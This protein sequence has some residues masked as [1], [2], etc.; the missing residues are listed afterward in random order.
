MAN[1][2]L[3]KKEENLYTG[4]IKKYD[5]NHLSVRIIYYMVFAVCLAI[6]IVCVFPFLWTILSSFKTIKEFSG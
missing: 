4:V 5:M 2:S 3:A 1:I 6:M